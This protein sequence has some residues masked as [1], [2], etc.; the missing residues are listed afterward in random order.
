LDFELPDQPK[1]ADTAPSLACYNIPSLAHRIVKLAQGHPLLASRLLCCPPEAMHCYAIFLQCHDEHDDAVNAQIIYETD[2]RTLLL[3]S[4]DAPAAELFSALK[5]CEPKAHTM[6][7]YRTL[8]ELLKGEFSGDLTDCTVINTNVLRF[9]NLVRRW[10]LDPLVVAA[11]RSL[12]YQMNRAT[13]FSD[14]IGIMRALNVLNADEIERR[15]LHNWKK[16][17]YCYI[18]RRLQRVASPLAFNLVSPLIQVRDAK[19]LN[20]LARKFE[21]CLNT[22]EHRVRLASGNYLLVHLVEGLAEHPEG[23]VAVLELGA[24]GIW[25]ISDAEHARSVECP[26]EVRNRI[27]E[28]LEQS[29]VK[30]APRTYTKAMRF[31]ANAPDLMSW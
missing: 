18:D 26:P 24:G 20:R 28:L 2:P 19:H 5:K 1:T 29:G 22:M 30:A 27:V 15:T 21:N 25:Y 11:H 6:A 17:L 16:S 12:N 3:G 10:H 9:F 8:N 14:I 31:F 23:A 7:F 13:A 4:I